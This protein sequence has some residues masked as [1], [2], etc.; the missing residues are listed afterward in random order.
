MVSLA[1]KVMT[2]T[3]PSSLVLLTADTARNSQQLE[4]AKMKVE[5]KNCGGLQGLQIL[6]GW[7]F[8]MYPVRRPLLLIGGPHSRVRESKPGL[9]T[10]R[11][12]GGPGTE[13]KT[14]IKSES[15]GYMS[16]CR[17]QMFYI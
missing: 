9:I 8:R 12:E 4:N 13:N 15:V 7:Y 17:I 5:R 2:W 6:P 1:R 14:R 3:G 16:I 11:K 10:L